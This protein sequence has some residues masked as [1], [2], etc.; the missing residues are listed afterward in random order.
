[1]EKRNH[2]MGQ[3]SCR[4]LG[5][6]S[7]PFSHGISCF[8]RLSC[9][10]SALLLW[11]LWGYY[12]IYT[13]FCLPASVCIILLWGKDNLGFIQSSADLWRFHYPSFNFHKKT[14]MQGPFDICLLLNKGLYLFCSDKKIPSSMLLMLIL[15]YHVCW[16]AWEPEEIWQQHRI[17]CLCGR[18]FWCKGKKWGILAWFVILVKWLLLKLIMSIVY[19][20]RLCPTC[21]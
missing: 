4:S 21:M 2:F 20:R 1:M 10:I 11:L 19:E 14:A 5:P 9:I 17:D 18:M 13:S 7:V 6:M 16:E 15:L 3:E 12:K 8:L